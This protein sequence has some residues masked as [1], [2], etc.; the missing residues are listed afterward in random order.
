MLIIYFCILPSDTLL[1][2][3]Q[4]LQFVVIASTIVVASLIAN[5]IA[6]GI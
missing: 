6:L 1:H 3:F 5:W 2:V 4:I